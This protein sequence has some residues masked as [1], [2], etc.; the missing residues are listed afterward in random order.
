MGKRYLIDTNVIIDY[1]SDLIPFE[2]GI[3]I[4]TIFNTDFNISVVVK[5][6]ALG[7]NEEIS[8]MSLLEEFITTATIIPLD[9]VVTQ[10]TIALRKIKKL[11]LGDAIIAAT[12]IVHDLIIVTRNISDFQNI[13]ELKV[14]NSHK[15]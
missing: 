4:E 11:K 9:D 3:F 13:P 1:S 5:I 8:K 14:I 12:A 6:E 15:L 2:S 7:Y 10:K